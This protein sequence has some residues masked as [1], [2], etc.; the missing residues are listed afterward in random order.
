MHLSAAFDAGNILVLDAHDPSAVRLAIRDDVGGEHKQWFHFRASGV[1]GVPCNYRIE[2]AASCSY[3]LGWEGYRAVASVDRERWVRVPTRYEDGAL[4]ITHTPE[5]DSVWYAYFAPYS[6]ERHHDLVARSAASPFA[7]HEVLGRTIDG[8]DLDLVQI[9]EAGPGKRVVWTIAPQ[10]PGES[11]AEWW[12]E[13]WLARL[14]DPH[15]ALARSVRERAV[16]Y[17]VPNMNPDGSA[18][19]HLRTNAVGANLNREWHEPTVERAPEVKWVRDRMDATGVDLALDVHGDEALPYNFIAG[20]EGIA[21]YTPRMASLQDAFEAAYERACP[22]F[23]RVHGY[24][25]DAPRSGNMTMHTNQIAA[26]FDCL[27]M[28]LEMPFKDNAAAPDDGQGWSPERSRRLGAA[29]IDP[30]AAVLDA[31]R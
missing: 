2:N 7:R 29:A 25:K 1:R 11:M 4:V 26:R 27:A 23:Q 10:H 13:G 20:A 12:M 28:T 18:R 24:P 15:D 30:V 6:M 22:D 17:V 5:A 31:L 16:L 19:G 8:R 3:P 21:G 9:G 14:L